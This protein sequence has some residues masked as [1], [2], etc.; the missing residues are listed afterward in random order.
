MTDIRDTC[1]FF[2]RQQICAPSFKSTEY[3]EDWC[4]AKEVE[5][6]R[7]STRPCIIFVRPP[8]NYSGI[9]QTYDISQLLSVVFVAEGYCTQLGVFPLT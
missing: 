5:E 9:K 3:R 2:L 7:P 6:Y 4:L 1:T 8:S